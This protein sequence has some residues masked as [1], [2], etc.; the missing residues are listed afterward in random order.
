LTIV[1]GK[2]GVGRSSSVALPRGG[3]SQTVELILAA[4][5]KLSGVV[6]KDGAPVADTVVI[7]HPIAATASNF[8]VV[9]GADG[10]YALDALTADEY[11]AYPMIGGGG[12]RPKDMYLLPAR[13]APG[14]TTRHDINYE[15]G[16]LELAVRVTTDDNTPV[17]AAAV[18]LIG[19][20]IDVP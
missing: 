13:I 3:E 12:P 18:F 2:D 14:E 19:I 15:T 5:G 8:F 1:A 11:I 6:R 17:A 10:S 7:A 16:A 9:T 20:E 4:T